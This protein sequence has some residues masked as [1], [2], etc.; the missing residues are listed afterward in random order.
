MEHHIIN[1]QTYQDSHRE[2][3]KPLLDELK[4]PFKITAQLGRVSPKANWVIN[5]RNGIVAASDKYVMKKLFLS[6]DIPTPKLY[7]YW[8]A[9]W[10]ALCGRKLVI[11]GTERKNGE[12]YVEMFT[13]QNVKGSYIEDYFLTQ[14]EFRVHASPVLGEV[15]AVE[16]I[17]RKVSKWKKH[18]KDCRFLSDFYR[19]LDWDKVVAACMTAVEVLGLDIGACDVM[20]NSDG[21]TIAEVNSAPGMGRNTAQAY[22]EAIYNIAI[23]KYGDDS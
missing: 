13:G 8:D 3:L 20:W 19:P 18:L 4:L 22:A 7:S 1:L 14:R 9:W 15:F 21:F 12:G 5:S 17:D 23:Y 2:L 10:L 16:K 6:H 11:K